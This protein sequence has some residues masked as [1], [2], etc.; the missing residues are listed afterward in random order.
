MCE[1][2]NNGNFDRRDFLKI[3]G[4][5]ATLGTLLATTAL[6]QNGDGSP[7][8][9]AIEKKKAK[10]TV[11]FLYP[12]ANVVNEGRLED[13]WAVHQWFT[14][15]GNQFEPEMNQEKYTK[16]IVEF[17]KTYEIDLDFQGVVYTRAGLAEFIAKTQAAPPDTLL[18]VN[19]WNSFSPWVF[20]MSQQ[21]APLPMIVYHPVGSNHQHPPKELMT[22]PGM[23]Y[24]HSLENWEV[25]ENAMAAANARKMMSQSRLLRITE[26][27][28]PTKDIDKNL[29]VEIVAVPA[30]EYNHLFDSI[31]ADDALIRE[32]M[33][34]KAKATAVIDVEDQYFI[35]GFRSRTA[36]LD[37]MKRYGA[38]GITIRCLMLKERKPCI[39]FSLNNSALVPCACED[40]P[41]SAM[42]LMIGTRLFNR[43]GF[44]HNP[45]YD[46]DR[47]QYYG[48]HC[49]CALELHGPGKGEMPF[50]IRPFAHQ[51]PKTAAI[52][53]RMTP[54]EK[55]F[56]MKYIPPQNRIFAFT[57]TM[58]GS[59]EFNTAGG[60]ATRF[61]MDVDKTDD[62]C[63]T[64][65]GPHPILYFGTVMEAKR[66][67]AFAKL[68]QLEF[69]GNV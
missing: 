26:V 4:T 53:V 42:S 10:I 61:V 35:D 2:C 23:V 40:F 66:I 11:L 55:V 59:P 13:G 56:L 46:I 33:A 5:A 7:G 44:M 64:Y 49:T 6:A 3:G 38:D 54:G 37:I 14:Y 65:Q 27:N 62:V 45:E 48:S 63:S 57:G 67:K 12:P 30:E 19:F 17:A 47:N 28:E 9:V 21:L 15:P 32:A 58:V 68:T 25:L 29:G 60:C 39:A 36:V 50:R 20:E 41:D 52:D 1:T 34:F 69:T 31:K 51:L 43:G 18:V 24:I 22:A 8:A 16:K